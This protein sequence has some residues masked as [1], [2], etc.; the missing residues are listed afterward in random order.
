MS[1]C[2]QRKYRRVHQILKVCGGAVSNVIVD[3]VH[4]LCRWVWVDWNSLICKL[5]PVQAG[6]AAAVMVRKLLRYQ[7][8]ANS[9]VLS[10]AVGIGGDHSRYGVDSDLN[11]WVSPSFGLCFKLDVKILI[12][13]DMYW[14]KVLTQL[15]L[16]VQFV[17][18]IRIQCA[19]SST[20]NADV[21]KHIIKAGIHNTTS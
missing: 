4:V 8:F 1:S 3:V 21:Q 9:W 10:C 6:C 20:N 19:P 15:A 17:Q 12:W 14:T 18:C 2:I 16:I 13:R 5:N 7:R 11:T